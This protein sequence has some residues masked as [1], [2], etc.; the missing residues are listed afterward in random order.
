MQAIAWALIFAL[1]RAGK[2]RLA[3]MAMI[4]MTTSNSI[5]E[6]AARDMRTLPAGEFMDNSDDT[7][8]RFFNQFSGPADRCHRKITKLQDS[9]GFPLECCCGK[10]WQMRSG[11]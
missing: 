8:I 4:A 1:L 6:K 5:S 7:E 2:R 3:R 9:W 11:S 10:L